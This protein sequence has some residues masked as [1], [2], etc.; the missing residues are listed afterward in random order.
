MK[1]IFYS[2][3]ER[4]QRPHRPHPLPRCDRGAGALAEPIAAEYRKIAL[5]EP[6]QRGQLRLK[7]TKMEE[8]LKAYAVAADYGVADVTTAATYRIATVYRTSPRR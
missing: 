1:D 5:V 7:K 6:L 2:R 3:P 4:R 8:A